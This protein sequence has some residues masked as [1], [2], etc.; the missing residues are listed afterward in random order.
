MER[1]TGNLANL[2]GTSEAFYSGAL[3]RL[4]RMMLLIAIV[5]SAAI[6]LRFGWKS[7]AGFAVGAAIAYVNFHWLKRAVS[8]LSDR[9]T[10][11]DSTRRGSRV[12]LR[13][14]LRYLIA[15]LAAFALLRVAPQSLRG[16]LAGLFLPVPAIL[17]E[18][19]YEL[20]IALVR[21]I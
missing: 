5:A 13:F 10:G 7:G 18:A 2:D 1:Q 19:M 9:V 4:A 15:G 3:A 11:H 16:F 17:L 14:V 21:G 8:A 20:Y 12:V 6:G